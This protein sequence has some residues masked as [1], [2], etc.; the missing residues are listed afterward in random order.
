MLNEIDLRIKMNLRKRLIQ[1]SKDQKKKEI[2]DEK[3]MCNRIMNMKFNDYIEYL[4]TH[5]LRV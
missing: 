4:R 2:T 5:K 3:C 1:P